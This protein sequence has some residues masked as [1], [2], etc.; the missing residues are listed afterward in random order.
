MS[1]KTEKTEELLPAHAGMVPPRPTGL[2]SSVTAPRARGDGPDIP[3]GKLDKVICS[4]RTR[5]WSFGPPSALPD[6]PLLPAH[7][8][9]VQ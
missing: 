3:Y 8:G 9:M 5:G 1:E 7:A 4:P 6:A 2:R